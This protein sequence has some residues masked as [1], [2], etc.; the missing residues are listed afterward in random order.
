M[1]GMPLGQCL[2]KSRSIIAYDVP[3]IAFARSVRLQIIWLTMQVQQDLK[4]A[5][6]VFA[7]LGFKSDRIAPLN[8]GCGALYHVQQPSKASNVKDG[9]QL[10]NRWARSL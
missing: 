8:E 5:S 1:T 2:M 10:G 6:L 3:D 9:N 4:A 7:H